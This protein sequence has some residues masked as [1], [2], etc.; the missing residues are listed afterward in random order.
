[1]KPI[2]IDSN[3]WHFKLIKYCDYYPHRITDI[4]EYRWAL[5]KSLFWSG[6][7]CLIVLFMCSVLAYLI[8]NS[9]AW[10]LAM[11]VFGNFIMPDAGGAIGTALTL[12]VSLGFILY[13]ASVKSI[14][15]I[16]ELSQNTVLSVM[17]DSWKNK[18]CVP[19][20]IKDDHE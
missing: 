19:I 9:L 14:G 11:I 3:S 15:K 1:M 12:A 10:I 16:Q 2:E 17:Y 18:W 13:T 8:T 20:V 4:C 6:L 7:G 5:I